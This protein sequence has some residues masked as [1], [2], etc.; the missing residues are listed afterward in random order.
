[1][2]R[3]PALWVMRTASRARGCDVMGESK[4]GRDDDEKDD[5]DGSPQSIYQASG[6]K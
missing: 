3:G 2:H 1:M 6:I 5:D 4:A